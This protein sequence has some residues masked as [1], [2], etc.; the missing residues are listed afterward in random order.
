MQNQHRQLAAILFTD[1][2]NYTAMMQQDEA[3]AVVVVKRYISVLQKTV[4]Q[5]EGTV[6]NDYGDGTLCSFASATQ[7]VKC[8]VAMQQQ[9]QMDPSVPLR[10]GLHVG[11]I[12]FEEGKVLGDG[13]NVASRIQSLGQGNTI[14]FSREICDKIRNQ[15]EFKSVSLGMFEFKNVDEPMEVFALSNEGLI[16][17]RRENMEGKLKEVKKK[18]VHKKLSITLIVFLLLLIVFYT[19][20][21][22]FSVSGFSGGDKTIAVLPF[23]NLGLPDSDEYISDGITEEVINNLSKISSLEKVISWY[24]AKTFKGTKKTIN[25]IAAE[26]NVSAVLTGTLEKEGNTI[27]VI[28]ELTDVDSRKRLWGEVMDYDINEI[29]TIQTVIAEQIVTALQASVTPQEK[30]DLSRQNTENPEAYKLYR[31]GL[32][33]WE[34]NTQ[35]NFDSAES[36]YRKALEID[37][38]YALAY[39]GLANCYIFSTKFSSQVESIPIAKAYL[40]KALSLD[41]NLSESL[42]TLGWIQ[43]AFDYDWKKSKITLEKAIRLNPNYGLAHLWYGNLLQYTGENT[44]KGIDEVKRALELD[45]LNGRFNWVLARNYYFA[46]ENNLALEQAKKTLIVNPKFY[47]AKWIFIDVFLEKKMYPQAFEFIKQL[48]KISKLNSIS[49]GPFFAYA[50]AVSGDT[51]KAKLE[52]ER[53]LKENP[54]QSPFYLS[55]VYIALKNYN[56]AL[57]ELDQ[58]YDKRDIDLYFIKVDPILDPI[59]NEPRFKSLL[60]KM[61]L[62]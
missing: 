15:Q 3:R 22:F 6:L 51:N 39:S 62:D 31:K 59:R 40:Q 9:L 60:K 48:P 57:D 34:K 20:K 49:Q 56:V 33:S 12:F 25:Q 41:S 2:V 24:S 5:Y 35:E 4:P 58:A 18:P 47:L 21:H 61:N 29:P 30:K 16:V 26:L 42:T 52:L 37:P 43:G 50:Y 28:A 1:I 46:G 19:Y 14:L 11:E 8:A 44:A 54:D 27:H 17:P 7:A 55:H 32:F 45:P 36:Y 23:D 38:D 10:I 53:M 13:V